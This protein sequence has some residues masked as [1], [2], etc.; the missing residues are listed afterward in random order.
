MTSKA[1]RMLSRTSYLNNTSQ[2][3]KD[4]ILGIQHDLTSINTNLR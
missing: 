4:Q 1:H 2:A 3:L